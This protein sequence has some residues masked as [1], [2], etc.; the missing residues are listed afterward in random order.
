MKKRCGACGKETD[1]PFCPI[2]KTQTKVVT[3]ITDFEEGWKMMCSDLENE[4]D[5]KTTGGKKSF[6]VWYEGGNSL[7]YKKSTGN[8]CDL[9]KSEF[10]KAFAIYLETNTPYK[11]TPYTDLMHG[12]YY[13][14]LL[15]TYFLTIED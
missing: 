8:I 15:K 13:P 5:F 11:T 2:C 7:K 9:P 12:S 4:K 10:E 6:V 1:A 14:P 3:K